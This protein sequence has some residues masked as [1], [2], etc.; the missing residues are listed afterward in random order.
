MTEASAFAVNELQAIRERLS[1]FRGICEQTPLHHLLAPLYFL[2]LMLTKLIKA[3]AE[4]EIIE[5]P[6]FAEW[7]NPFE[8]LP[9]EK[10]EQLKMQ[11]MERKYLTVTHL[12]RGHQLP[13]HRVRQ[14]LIAEGVLKPRRKDRILEIQDQILSMYSRGL[15]QTEIAAATGTTR[16]TVASICDEYGLRKDREKELVS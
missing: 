10:I 11:W 3:E 6:E 12:A 5:R 9:R 4:P 7:Y 14:A 15:S 8:P 2:D 1:L 16:Q 13:V